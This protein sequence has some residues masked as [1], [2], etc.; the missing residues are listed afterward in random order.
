MPGKAV[1]A[2]RGQGMPHPRPRRVTTGIAAR[3]CVKFRFFSS[4]LSQFLGNA[5][6]YI[7]EDA[8]DRIT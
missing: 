7:Q 1:V 2:H 3:L 6:H 5:R 8:P 4:L